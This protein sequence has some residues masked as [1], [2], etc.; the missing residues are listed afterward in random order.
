MLFKIEEFLLYKEYP[1]FK[2]LYEELKP[3]YKE[4][5]FAILRV[6][7]KR[8]LIAANICLF[9]RYAMELAFPLLLKLMLEWVGDEEAEDYLGYV[10]AG[11]LS[12]ALGIKSYT[13]ILSGYFADYANAKIRSGIKVFFLD[14]FFYRLI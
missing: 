13:N 2:K 14:Y 4:D 9:I 10:Y 7:V 1:N 6:Y 5:L 11:G 8:Y 3:K 12:L